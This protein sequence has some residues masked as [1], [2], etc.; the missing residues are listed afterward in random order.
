MCLF[1]YL[2]GRSKKSHEKDSRLKVKGMRFEVK[3]ERNEI[4]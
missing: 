2:S 3:I 1:K 4:D